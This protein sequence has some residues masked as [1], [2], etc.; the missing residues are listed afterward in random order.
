M[1]AFISFETCRIEADSTP[2]SKACQFPCFILYT[3][4]HTKYQNQSPEWESC[5]LQTKHGTVYVSLHHTEDTQK[6]QKVSPPNHNNLICLTVVS[7]YKF[8]KRAQHFP[9]GVS[10]FTST[11][12]IITVFFFT[13]E[14][15][16][17]VDQ[18]LL[19][20]QDP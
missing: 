9:L 8:E 10:C 17:L 12:E 6:P 20:I 2:N 15:K 16:P 7:S 4:K 18:G 3:S 5:Q 1:S 11:N 13:M 14:Q 19:I